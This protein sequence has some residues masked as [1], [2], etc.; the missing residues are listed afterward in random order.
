MNNFVFVPFIFFAL[1]CY[2]FLGVELQDRTWAFVILLDIDKLSSIEVIILQSH[3][4][5]NVN[6]Y[7]LPNFWI[8]V[9]VIDSFWYVHEGL[10]YF[11]LMN[12]IEY[13]FIYLEIIYSHFFLWVRWSYILPIFFYCFWV[14]FILIFIAFYIIY[15]MCVLSLILF[16]SLPCRFFFCHAEDFCFYIVIVFRFLSSWKGFIYYTYNHIIIIHFVLVLKCHIV[17]INMY[18][19]SISWK[20][21]I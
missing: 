12:E 10:F 3:Q 4:Q 19:Y 2:R 21:K 18:N 7:V 15:R 14:P 13:L 11:S 9:S 20:L 17:P 1:C 6:A 8:F 16:I 5:K